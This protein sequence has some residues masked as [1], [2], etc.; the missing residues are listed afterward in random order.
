MQ[1]ELETP[2]P[3]G[4]APVALSFPRIVLSDG[5][6]AVLCADPVEGHVEMQLVNLSTREVAGEA[7]AP[8]PECP[9]GYEAGPFYSRAIER[10]AQK[11]LQAFA[12]HIKSSVAVPAKPKLIIPGR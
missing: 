10:L 7:A 1:P 12:D 2:P 3:N 4:R 5:P 9:S 6:F 11:M 8:L